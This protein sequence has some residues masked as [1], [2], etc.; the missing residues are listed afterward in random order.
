[1]CLCVDFE[2]DFRGR[3]LERAAL[4]ALPPQDLGN[5]IHAAQVRAELILQA[6]VIYARLRFRVCQCCAAPAMPWQT[7]EA[8]RSSD[9]TVVVL[10]SWTSY[11]CTTKHANSKSQP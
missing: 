3:Q 1:M 8:L 7:V 10:C 11:G 4:C 9:S 5:A 2:F 6:L